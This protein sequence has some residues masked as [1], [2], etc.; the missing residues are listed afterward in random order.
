ML[1]WK[2]IRESQRNL[3]GVEGWGTIRKHAGHLAP[4]RWLVSLRILRCTI[5]TVSTAS[6]ILVP[7]V[8]VAAPAPVEN[9]ADDDTDGSEEEPD[10]SDNEEEVGLPLP[11]P[12]EIEDPLFDAIPWKEVPIP[13]RPQRISGNSIQLLPMSDIKPRP[14]RRPGL[15][16][17]QGCADLT[18][19]LEFFTKLFTMEIIRVFVDATNAYA[20]ARN[21][22]SWVNLSVAEFKAFLALV[23]YYGVVSIPSRRMAWTTSSIFNM[24]WPSSVMTCDRFESIMNNWHWID[25]SHMGNEERKVKNK[26]NS[27]WT[28][29]GFCDALARSFSAYYICPQCFDIDEQCI[30]WKGRHMFK[31]YNPNK[32]AK[33]HLK[34]YALNCADTSYQMNFFMYQGRDE[35][36]PQGMAATVFPI[37][38]LLKDRSHW[39]KNMILYIDNSY[40]SI[41]VVTLCR[42]WGIHVVGTTHV[43]KKGLPKEGIFAKSGRARRERGAMKCMAKPFDPNG[44]D[45]LYF[46]AW[47]DSKPVHILHTTK[48]FQQ[49]VERTK[50]G[51]NRRDLIPQ[52]SV[53]EDYNYGMRGTDGMNQ[54]ISYYRN[55]MHS[56]KWQPRLFMHFLHTTVCNA[57]I[58]FKESTLA[59]RGD[60]GFTLLSFTESLICQ[61]TEEHFQAERSSGERTSK[62]SRRMEACMADP[63]RVIGNNHYPRQ[64]RRLKGAP[65]PRRKCKICNKKVGVIC[66]VCNIAVCIDYHTNRETCWE[67]YHT[68][69][70]S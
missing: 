39:H 8:A 18:T 19:A 12:D 43:N 53:V 13:Q 22:V 49:T 31:C 7:A 36:R 42:D 61:L 21:R 15:T 16:G 56:K 14:G 50:K 57:H 69:P 11:A 44:Q 70:L 2:G 46:T 27:F 17:V 26:Q 5:L 32:P 54:M 4:H 51:T 6:N 1:V 23:L 29:Q 64:L 30:P 67:K 33:W 55:D 38:N 52:P 47:M 66:S 40:S 10:G 28:V 63:N 3:S 9:G 68:M 65:D 34:V 58:L 45:H 62:K 59:N 25:T 48:P 20:T 24:P 37:W 35:D 60:A 41:A